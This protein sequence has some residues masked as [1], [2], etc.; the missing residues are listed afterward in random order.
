VNPARI[1]IATPVMAAVPGAGHVTVHY[2]MSMLRIIQRFA[3]IAIT[4]ANAF[5]NTD[6]V[7]AR[8]RA[9]RAALDGCY[10]HLLFWDSDVGGTCADAL[11]GMLAT[12]KDVVACPY[13]RKNLS[14]RSTHEPPFVAMGFTLISERCMRNMWDA[15]YDELQFDDVIDGRPYRTVAMF[16]LLMVDLDKP[17]P[18][19]TLLGE[20]YSFCERWL[21]LDEEIHLYEGPGSPLEHVGGHVFAS[22]AAGKM[23]V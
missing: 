12:G 17:H 9:V 21:R 1:M 8:S 20:D 14:G 10:T 6:L 3:N 19:R 7:R 2:Q 23:T 5:V 4:S 22:Q 11:H 18:H 16:N 15:Y 13:P